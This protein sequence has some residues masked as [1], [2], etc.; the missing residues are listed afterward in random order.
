MIW[1]NSSS[2]ETKK[3]KKEE[4]VSSTHRRLTIKATTWKGPQY[5]T[6]IDLAWDTTAANSAKFREE[7]CS[8]KYES[9]LIF[10]RVN[11]SAWVAADQN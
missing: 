2:A 9:C 6:E 7:N 5:F 4:N 1:T 10:V 3:K 8:K 11:Q